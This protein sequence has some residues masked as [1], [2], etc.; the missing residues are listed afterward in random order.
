VSSRPLVV[1]EFQGLLYLAGF[2]LRTKLLDG[3]TTRSEELLELP[4]AEVYAIDVHESISVAEELV[5]NVLAGSG[6]SPVIVI[7]DEFEDASAF[8]LLSFGVRG[9]LRRADMPRQLPYALKAVA[10]GGFWV[11]RPMLARFVDSVIGTVRRS[12]FALASADL[13]GPDLNLLDA[14]LQNLSDAQVAKRFNMSEE[15][16]KSRVA[17]LLEKFHVRRRAD[18]ILLAHQP[19]TG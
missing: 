2:A 17:R 7:T 5:A 14:L 1:A 8:R 3:E 6:G 18:L 12:R 4:P 11:P 19:P 9:L 15:D 13:S 16:V 10:G